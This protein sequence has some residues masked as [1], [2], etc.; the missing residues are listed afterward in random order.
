MELQRTDSYSKAYSEILQIINNMG[1]TYKKKIPTKL[2]EFFEKNKD[3]DY[4]YKLDKTTDN[5]DKVISPKTIGLL[6]MIEEKYWAKDDE[7]ELLK[8]AL[9]ENEKTFQEEL[10]KKYNPD[11]LFENKKQE[12]IQE[13]NT[14]VNNVSMIE[15]K[16]NFFTR[17]INKI[18]KIFKKY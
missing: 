4:N 13:E 10:R 11:N 18:K 17:I 9:K 16:A 3:L 1:E 14:A 2:L 8:Q 7:K 12:V 6:A 15:Y 5:S